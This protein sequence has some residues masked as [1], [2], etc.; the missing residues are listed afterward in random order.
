MKTETES[1][2]LYKSSKFLISPEKNSFQS[3]SDHQFLKDL[4]KKKM[5]SFHSFKKELQVKGKNLFNKMKMLKENVNCENKENSQNV[6][7]RFSSN[8]SVANKSFILKSFFQIKLKE[9][10]LHEPSQPLKLSE[11][12]DGLTE[13]KS[14]YMK[15]YRS[16]RIKKIK[17]DDRLVRHRVSRSGFDIQSKLIQEKHE[18]KKSSDSFLGNKLKNLSFNKKLIYKNKLRIFFKKMKSSLIGNI[19]DVDKENVNLGQVSQRKSFMIMNDMKQ[20]KIRKIEEKP[21]KVL[22]APGIS[23][24]FYTH[25]QDV[26]SKGILFI[27][28]NS[29]V[30]S[31]DLEHNKT[32]KIKTSFQN[33]PS[34]IKSDPDG[35]KVIIGDIKGY[36]NLVDIQKNCYLMKSKPHKG[37]LGICSFIDQNTIITGGKDSYLKVIDLRTKNFSSNFVIFR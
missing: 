22:D 18:R 13:N 6:P 16:K 29:I 37:R 17:L 28:L 12:D 35:T 36:L 3:N 25:T 14:N 20:R 31:F 24:D 7:K 4:S 32:Q 2:I 27:S 9:K 5:N 15:L 19:D 30:Y 23:D 34:C 8:I 11:F 21:S 1:E 26:S 33:S 10:D